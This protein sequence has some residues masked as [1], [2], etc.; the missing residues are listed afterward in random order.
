MKDILEQRIK[1]LEA[2]A[3]SKEL[4]AIEVETCT[5][6]IQYRFSNYVYTD[7]NSNLYSLTDPDVL[8]FIPYEYQ[9]EAANE[10]WSSIMNGTFALEERYDLTNIFIEKSRQMG[11]SWLIMAVLVY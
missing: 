1:L 9:V 8:P 3:E 5:L 11:L 7:K 10:I 4:Q 6:D 2:C